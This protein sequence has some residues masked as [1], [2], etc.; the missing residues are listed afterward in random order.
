MD[1]Y[2][3]AFNAALL[4]ATARLDERYFR[5]AVTGQA[6]PAVRE[7]AYCY[8]LYHQL[9]LALP[10]HDEFPFALHGEVDKRGHPALTE[11]VGG[12][13][14]DFI[15]HTPGEQGPGANLAVVEVKGCGVFGDPRTKDADSLVAFVERAEY[16]KGVAVVFGG[17]QDGLDRHLRTVFPHAIGLAA[18]IEIYWHSEVGHPAQ[19]IPE[20]WRRFPQ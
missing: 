8:E 16:F 12:R 4:A 19:P 2:W 17:D 6:Q 13:N 20:W 5:L 11:A 3:Q 14:P 9:R 15:V 1:Q 18:R 10:N 7:R